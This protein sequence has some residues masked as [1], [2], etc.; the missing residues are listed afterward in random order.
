L[1]VV[2][3]VLGGVLLV[4]GV[5]IGVLTW[6]ARARFN[7]ALA[8]AQMEA[9]TPPPTAAPSPSQAT[10]PEQ[11]ERLAADSWP[12]DAQRIEAGFS[13]ARS[14]RARGE[15][16]IASR[17]LDDVGLLLEKYRGTRVAR[18]KDWLAY[19]ARF[20]SEREAEARREGASGHEHIGGD[21][22]VF[23]DVLQ[24]RYEG[25]RV[26]VAG[27]FRALGH[28]GAH[29]YINLVAES[30][31]QGPVVVCEIET[32]PSPPLRPDQRL[33]VSGLARG[34]VLKDCTY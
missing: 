14:A 29:S 16:F 9:S 34:A 19:E 7:A 20:E 18:S 25:K 6:S 11:A 21:S 13:S 5:G 23:Q 30:G 17:A 26:V 12:Q 8:A 24:G 31:Q 1:L 27:Y 10:D 4:L 3:L 28:L 2:A 32:D 22:A 15:W 33:S